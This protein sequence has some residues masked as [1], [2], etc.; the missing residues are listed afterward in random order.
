MLI[1]KNVFV[2]FDL[3]VLADTQIQSELLSMQDSRFY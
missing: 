3:L 2:K 1:L